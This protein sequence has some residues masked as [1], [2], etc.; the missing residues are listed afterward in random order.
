V[1]GGG[2]L[3]LLQHR[4]RKARVRRTE[5]KGEGGL[6]WRELI[7]RGGRGGGG[8]SSSAVD[9]KLQHRSGQK[10]MESGGALCAAQSEEKR[11]AGKI[12]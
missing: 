1:I 7:E 4:G 9:N 11:G 6:P 3:G 8:F 2:R 12:K 10:E 5:L